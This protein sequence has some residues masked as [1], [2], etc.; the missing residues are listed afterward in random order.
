MNPTVITDCYKNQKKDIYI[1]IYVY[2]NKNQ[3]KDIYIYIYVY[4]NNIIYT[5]M[6]FGHGSGTILVPFVFFSM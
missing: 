4:N 6:S 3:K 1:Y 5:L 2:N